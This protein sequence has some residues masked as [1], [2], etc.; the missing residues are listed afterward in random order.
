MY[1][2]FVVIA[3]VLGTAALP[4]FAQVEV[5]DSQP[6]G[7]SQPS[8]NNSA[9]S[10]NQNDAA[11]TTAQAELYYQVQLLQEEVQ[12]LRGLVEQQT[13][14]L[15]RLQQQRLDDYLDLDRRVGQLSEAASAQPAASSN[16]TR[17][18]PVQA[19]P[20]DRAQREAVAA[21]DELAS[22]RKAI[23]L[24]LKQR[25]FDAGI[26][27]LKEHLQQ[28]PRGHYV[29]NAQY[30]LG[31]I[32]LQKNELS[33]SKDWF[34]RMINEHANHQKAPEAKFKLGKVHHLLGNTEQAKTILREVASAN[35]A[36]AS[37]AEDY[38]EQNF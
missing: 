14:Q 19:Q 27:A 35:V 20:D 13:H 29:A 37:L 28:F 26:E 25:D 21:E 3:A 8:A 18:P 33:Q 5:V 34:A 9:S 2:H 24:V 12:E 1:K 32:Y 30:W 16:Q 36:V 22:Y 23:D 15:K 31:Q 10:R 38:L 6:V 7:R 11:A 17:Q 4:V